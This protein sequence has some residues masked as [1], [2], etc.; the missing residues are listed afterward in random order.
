VSGGLIAPH[1]GRLVNRLITGDGRQAALTRAARLP[2]ITL[3]GWA[4]SD[5][6]VIATG[7]LSPLEGFMSEAEVT[8]VLEHRRLPSGLVWTLPVTLIVTEAEANGI[9]AGREVALVDEARTPLAILTVTQAYRYDKMAYAQGSFGTTDRAH[10]GVSR[11][12]AQG[13]VFLAGPLTVVTL[14]RH[15]D[16]LANRLT[17]AQTRAEF[18]QRGWQRVVGFQTR[19]PIHRAHEYLLKVALEVTDGLLIHPLVGETKADD[20]PAEVRMRCYEVLIEKYFPRDRVL[21]AVNPASMR[22][23]GPREAVFHAIVRKN[24][25]CTHFIVG[26]DHAGA[27]TFYGPFDAQRIFSEFAPEELGITPLFFDNAFYCRAC[28][29]MA[30]TKSCPHGPAS[31]VSLSGTAVRALLK[32]GKLPPPEFSRPE[33]AQILI[34]AMAAQP[35]RT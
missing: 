18:A 13:E 14:P 19:N 29:G 35:V 4:Q 16:V 26:R 9:D 24:Y 31:R 17:P 7:A 28:G 32:E 34:E 8:H 25:G 10:P 5:V 1:G 20:V 11:L 27:G 15:D 33:V 21:L 2:T 30:S 22:Y 3:D 6:E 12:L 23:A